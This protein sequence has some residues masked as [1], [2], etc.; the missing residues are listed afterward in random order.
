MLL[1]ALHAGC[2]MGS[3]PPEVP[4]APAARA[5][6]EPS[7]LSPAFEA[8]D[9]SPA[10]R[11]EIVA[12]RAEL[13]RRARPFERSLRQLGLAVAAA[14]R[15]CDPDDMG[16]ES[17]ISWSVRTGERLREPLLEAVNRLHSILEPAQR[18]VL[19]KRLL[20][21]AE[22]SDSKRS[23]K[24]GARSL[25][26]EL[27]LSFGQMFAL[28]ARAEA[29]RSHFTEQVDPWRDKLKSAIAAFPDEGFDV[30]DHT[31]ARAP[32]LALVGRL[33]RSGV[34]T[35]MPILEP[36]QCTA[37]GGYLEHAVREQEER[38]RERDAARQ[39][40]DP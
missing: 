24:K 32:I 15:R 14:S 11:T 19:S 20:A 10:Q 21:G 1:G 16:V 22:R 40:E 2:Q 35:L 4:E 29:L 26:D 27:D 3:A 18:R 31:V 28:L 12:L 8:L 5:D 36:E 34:R 7:R 37:L 17:A 9:L 33:L 6:D 23:T 39:A 38:A 30:H 13:T 25:G